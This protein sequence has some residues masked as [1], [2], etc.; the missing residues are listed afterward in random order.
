METNASSLHSG[1]LQYAGCPPSM[2][3]RDEVDDPCAPARGI[4]LSLLLCSAVL[5]RRIPDAVLSF[6]LNPW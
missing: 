6:R 5:G 4:L 2:N 1:V 3:D